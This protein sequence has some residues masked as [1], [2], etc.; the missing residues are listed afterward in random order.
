MAAE[1]ERVAVG[2]ARSAERVAFND[3]IF[4]KANERIM[5][6]AE[7]LIERAAE[8][9]LEME[10]E[11]PFICE[12]AEESCTTP[13]RVPPDEYALVRSDPR[14]FLNAPGHEVAAQGWVEVIERHTD[15]YVA[16][17][18]GRA[19]EIAEALDE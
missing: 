1:P 19:G 16:E 11:P 7:R 9:G 5:E 17:K 14:R 3:D 13:I 6:G 8:I 15:Y 2:A 18:I 4:R 10:H 12:C